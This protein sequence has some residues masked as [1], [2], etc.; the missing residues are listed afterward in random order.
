MAWIR[1]FLKNL[2][3]ILLYPFQLF[4]VNLNQIFFLNSMSYKWGDNPKYIALYLRRLHN[5]DLKLV[6]AYKEISQKN[7]LESNGLIAV[8]YNTIQYFYYIMTSRVIITN[9]GG[10]SYLPIKKSQIVLNTWHGGGAYKKTGIDVYD[11]KYYIKDCRLNAKKTTAI[12]ISCKKFEEFG[13]PSMCFERC[14]KLPFGFPRND[15]FFAKNSNLREQVKKKLNISIDEKVM[16]YVPTYR[17]FE[18]NVLMRKEAFDGRLNVIKLLDELEKRWGGKWKFLYRLHPL[19]SGTLF[20]DITGA[21]NVSDY[22]DVQELLL[23]SD[24]MITDYSSIMWDFS[25]TGRP[26]FIFAPDLDSYMQSRDFYVPI[27]Q[28][29]F[30]LAHNN[31]ELLENIKKFASEDYMKNLK[32]HLKEMGS[33]ESGTAAESIAKWLVKVM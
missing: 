31:L 32:K 18:S 21:I 33:Y 8:K 16:L 12:L 17:N 9:N 29:P 19:A 15:L 14:T 20:D 10:I 25:L 27:A 13:I 7:I 6:Y 11:S 4:R 28:W 24:A 2:I 5:K 1:W 26:C 22:G 30:P 23:I 3:T